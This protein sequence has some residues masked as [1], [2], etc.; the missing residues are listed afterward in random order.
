M[1]KFNNPKLGE[2]NHEEIYFD[3]RKTLGDLKSLLSKIINISED[4]F[5]I[6]KN[7]NSLSEMTTFK[8][9]LVDLKFI[10]TEFLFL[11][12]GLSSKGSVIVHRGEVGL[13]NDRIEFNVF[14]EV[15]FE[16]GNDLI[17]ISD[18]CKKISESTGIP[19][20]NIRIR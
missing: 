10:G 6:K 15:Q 1:I 11:E 4:N 16:L 13:L 8:K 5:R 2:E 19:Q 18:L 9:K 7:K 14:E 20:E 17:T 3:T 12:E